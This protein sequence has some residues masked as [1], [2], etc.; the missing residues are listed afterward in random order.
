MLATLVALSSGCASYR[1]SS[2]LD[3][4]PLGTSTSLAPVQ[5]FEG[6]PEG[7]KFTRIGQVDVSIK[8]LTIFHSDPTRDM[9]NAA[10]TEKARSMGANAIINVNYVTGVGLT[11]WGY[12]DAM[13]MGVKIEE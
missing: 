5:I 6:Q 1:V 4:K 9:A 2:S 3:G 8:K 11:T 10:L 12:I 7:K 13:G